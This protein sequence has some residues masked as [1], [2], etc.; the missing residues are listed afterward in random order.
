[1]F[2]HERSLVK[3]LETKPFALL[4]I[5]TDPD[6]DDVI[7]KNS[8]NQITWRSWWDRSTTGPIS[9]QYNVR[10]F[11]TILVLDDKG[12]IRFTFKGAPGKKLDDAV[13]KLLKEMGAE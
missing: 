12:V 9:R 7:K 5:N 13:D 10:A 11:P 1:M 8:D 4:G 3:R 2:P 6:R